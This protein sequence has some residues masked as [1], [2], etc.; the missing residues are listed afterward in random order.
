M[1]KLIRQKNPI[2]APLGTGFEAKAV[3][4]PGIVKK[5][6]KVIMLYRAIGDLDTYIS[7]LGLAESENGIDFSRVSD[8]PAFSPGPTHIKG[9]IEDPRI[10]EMNGTFFITYVAV[11]QQVLEGGKEPVHRDLPLITSG[12]LLTTT[13]FKTFEDEGVITPLNADDKDMV[14]FPEKI[15]GRYAMIH[16]PFFW[17]QKGL[18]SPESEAYKIELPFE[19]EFLP[20][21]PTAWLSYSEDLR[22][23]T[24][25]AIMHDLLEENDGKIGPGLPPIKTP[26]GWL[27]IYHHVEVTEKGNIYSAKAAL[28]DLEDPTKAL[29][30]L[31]YSILYPEMPYETEGY[32]KNVVFPTGGFIENDTL[33][34]YYGAGDSCI[35]LA[36]GSV[37][38]LFR[39]F[40]AHR[41]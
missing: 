32:V 37:E 25:H 40:D 5:D 36:T 34:V 8:I 28:L 19:K 1:F 12:G 38:D 7:S 9:A 29:A 39:E 10:V 23:W 6:G 4:N 20:A 35:C 18:H 33:F 15:K 22:H 31:P 14:L 2:L 30:R 27:L 41:I 17:S 3:L 26:R 16:R 13:D 11:P 21:K 24:D